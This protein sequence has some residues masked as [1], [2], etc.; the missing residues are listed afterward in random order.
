MT[1]D[2]KR[3]SALLLALLVVCCAASERQSQLT[4]MTDSVVQSRLAGRP[5]VVLSEHQGVLSVAEAY[6]VQHEA[7]SQWLG[8]KRPMG[9]KAGLTAEVGQRKFSIDHPVAGVLL[10][11]RQPKLQQAVHR[12][13]TGD[14]NRAMLELEIGF[15]VKQ[16]ISTAID[17][18]EQLKGKI[19][20]VVPVIELPDL[21]FDSGGVPEATDIIANN[22]LA[23][24]YIV[25]QQRSL[26]DVTVD[27]IDV[28]LKKDGISI[29]QGHAT[30]AMGS[31]WLALRWLVN[32][33]IN[34]GWTI[35]PGQLLITGA[36][37]KMISANIGVYQAEFGH[38]GQINFVID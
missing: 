14:F 9:F 37:G 10:S 2:V 24:Q 31:Q 36:L 4:A 11:G 7:V 15:Q 1:H 8:A 22:V 26:D 20:A 21:A 33:T 30:D 23:K 12:V 18:I 38:L 19:A 13:D 28:V 32:Q 27:D 17:D 34:N 16:T 35:E 29:L 5:A 25:G 6:R 3:I